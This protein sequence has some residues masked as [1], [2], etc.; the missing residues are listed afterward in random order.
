MYDVKMCRSWH[1]CFS[2]SITT[3]RLMAVKL[4]IIFE[5]LS[6]LN[7]HLT[8]KWE[9]RPETENRNNI[10]ERPTRHSLGRPKSV[11]ENERMYTDM[12]WETVQLVQSVTPEREYSY[13]QCIH[14]GKPQGPQ[15]P[16]AGELAVS[17][18]PGLK[19]KH[20]HITADSQINPYT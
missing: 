16:L 7:V 6:D 10:P 4:W 12:N 11:P 2:M 18:A 17:V 8:N 19:E 5:G 9:R 15:G 3:L 14:L 1:R 13:I 20:S